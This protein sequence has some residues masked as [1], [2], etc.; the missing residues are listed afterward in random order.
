MNNTKRLVVMI[1]EC[2]KEKKGK[3]CVVLFVILYASL[4]RAELSSFLS[5]LSEE[6]GPYES[7]QGKHFMGSTSTLLN[8][9]TI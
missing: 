1:S 3:L 6:Q 8:R 5:F 2:K 7:R 4:L 9:I